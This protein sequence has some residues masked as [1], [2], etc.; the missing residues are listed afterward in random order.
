MISNAIFLV[1]LSKDSDIK[2]PNSNK[3][4]SKLLPV[5]VTAAEKGA[6]KKLLNYIEITNGE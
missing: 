2:L 3:N 5:S 1:N 6:N 4:W